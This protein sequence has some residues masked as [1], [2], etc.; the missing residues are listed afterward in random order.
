MKWLKDY[1]QL[2]YPEGAGDGL[3]FSFASGK[4]LDGFG[5]LHGIKRRKFLFIKEPDTLYKI[6]L[7][8]HGIKERE[9]AR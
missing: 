6:R 9:K 3:I 1:K 5:I 8:N 2:K 7:R 4:V